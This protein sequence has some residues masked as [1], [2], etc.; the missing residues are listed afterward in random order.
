[1]EDEEVAAT[2][3]L[4]NMKEAAAAQCFVVARQLDLLTSVGALDSPSLATQLCS[5]DHSLLPP[6]LQGP[7]SFS[8]LSIHAHTAYPTEFLVNGHGAPFNAAPLEGLPRPGE[9]D[10][11]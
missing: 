8:T 3:A 7:P 5:T 9:A 11:E 6:H 4:A 1:M 2:D 10:R